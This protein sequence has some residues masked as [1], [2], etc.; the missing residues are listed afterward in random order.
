MDGSAPTRAGW[1][2]ASS[3]ARDH[4]SISVMDLNIDKNRQKRFGLI[5]SVQHQLQFK[6]I[7]ILKNQKP[8]KSSEK[9]K[10]QSVYYFHSKFEF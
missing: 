9:L 1:P 7:Q 3:I 2:N 6:K 4:F 5:S 8:K 10:N